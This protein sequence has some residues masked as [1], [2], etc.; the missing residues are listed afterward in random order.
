MAE[1]T[2]GN[3][4]DGRKPHH[5]GVDKEELDCLP[6]DHGPTSPFY[7]HCYNRVGDNNA[8]GKPAPK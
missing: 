2:W 6:T 4:V 7:G 5:T 8:A 3:P 1:S